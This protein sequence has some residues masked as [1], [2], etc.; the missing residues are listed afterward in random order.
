MPQATGYTPHTAGVRGAAQEL[1]QVVKERI[2][3]QL[4]AEDVEFKRAEA[5]RKL[6]Q[7]D[8]GL[9]QDD[10]RI[11]ATVFGNDT[12]RMRAVDAIKAGAETRPSE[13]AL[14]TATVEKYNREPI[15]AQLERTHDLTLEGTKHTNALGLE[16]VRQTGDRR[17]EGLRQS[18]DMR[19][20]RARGEEDRRTQSERE[21][22]GTSLPAGLQSDLIDMG[23]IEMLSEEALTLGK[24]SNWAGVGGLYRGSAQQAAAKHLGMGKPSEQ[25]LRNL[26]GN[27]KGT[28]A[29]LRGGTAFS[30]GEKKLLDTYTPGIDEDGMVI[31]Q[32]LADLMSF[33]QNKRTMTGRV[34]GRD[35]SSFGGGRNGADAQ[36]RNASPADPRGGEPLAGGGGGAYTG[37]RR[38]LNGQTVGKLPSGEVIYLEQRG[39]QW[40]PVR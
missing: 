18:G 24:A 32:K 34:T 1:R 3:A 26:V 36:N 30:E 16:D 8:R 33:I 28:I 17:L 6:S 40:F 10:S 7:T 39:G 12:D 19:E 11:G 9:D 31:A 14:R 2:A 27:I 20:I 21:R 29:K 15:E 23:T 5:L 35:L 22:S 13:I 25:Q 37:E 4:L 38:T